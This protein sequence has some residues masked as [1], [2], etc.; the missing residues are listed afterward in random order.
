MA[1]KSVIIMGCFKTGTTTLQNLFNISD[2]V[3]VLRSHIDYDLLKQQKNSV[4]V[5][6]VPYR[7][8]ESL[9]KSAFFE[10][11]IDK[12]YV[13]C[14]FYEKNFYSEY[15]AYSEEA[16]QDLILN[17]DMSRL[18]EL[19]NKIKWGHHSHLD[20]L[21]GNRIVKEVMGI[22]DD[23]IKSGDDIVSYD[24]VS[25]KK[26]C[27]VLFVRTEKLKDIDYISSM[28]KMCNIDIKPKIMYSNSAK[29]KWYNKKYK[30]FLKTFNN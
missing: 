16:K 25:E 28:F 13:Y 8:Q 20:C 22:D 29:F 30:D 24:I 7:E 4:D 5:V 3:S 1:I 10:N 21:F 2:N 17:C 14:P 18:V 15:S 27:K 26:S 6:I 23:S 11:I 19:Y 9:Y 12:E